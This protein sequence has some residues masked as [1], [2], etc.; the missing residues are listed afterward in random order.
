MVSTWKL[1]LDGVASPLPAPTDPWSRIRLAQRNIVLGQSAEASEIIS[2]LHKS[3]KPNQAWSQFYWTML[4]QIRQL[5][6]NREQALKD[7]A[8]YR[9]IFRE[10]A[11]LDTMD[12]ILEAI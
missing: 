2:V 4:L 10:Q 7:Y 5:E 11:D 8:E 3:A 12:K 9:K 1:E 6:G